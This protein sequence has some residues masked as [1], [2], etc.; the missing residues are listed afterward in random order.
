MCGATIFVQHVGRSVAGKTDSSSFDFS[1]KHGF[2]QPLQEAA[3][4]VRKRGTDS[5][6][7]AKGS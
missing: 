6:R 7:Y 5:E 4:S 3:V 1:L 2:V